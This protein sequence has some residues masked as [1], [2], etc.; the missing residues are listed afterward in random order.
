[1]DNPNNIQVEDRVK[2]RKKELLKKT[3]KLAHKFRAGEIDLDALE[4]AL[5]KLNPHAPED[6]ENNNYYINNLKEYIQKFKDG[7][8]DPDLFISVLDINAV[9]ESF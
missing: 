5:L 2:K 3:H 8:Y 4:K 6:S 9:F 1:M 7:E